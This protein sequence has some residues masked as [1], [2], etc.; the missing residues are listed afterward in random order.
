MKNK[1]RDL[2]KRAYSAELET[3]ENYLA[4]SVWLDG[5]G[6]REVSES[7][8]EE[9]AEELGH[10]TKLARRLKQIGVC[11][12]GSLRMERSQ[13]SLQ[14]A[15]D[16]TDVRSVVKGV[17][18]AENEA[19]ALCQRLIKACDGKDPVTQDLAIGILADEEQHRTLFEGFLKSLKKGR[20]N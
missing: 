16:S 13:K 14:P 4:N 9:V 19:I 15:K 6:A 17:L 20:Q 18:D 2:L 11:P 8:A 12:P 1:I 3:V 5:I 10:A 7:L